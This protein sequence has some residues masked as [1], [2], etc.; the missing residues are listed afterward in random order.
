MELNNS[1][2]LWVLAHIQ[3]CT[4]HPKPTHAYSRIILLLLFFFVAMLELQSIFN[5]QLYHTKHLY[6]CIYSTF[7]ANSLS[8]FVCLCEFSLKI[9][10]FVAGIA[11]HIGSYFCA[12]MWKNEKFNLKSVYGYKCIVYMLLVFRFNCLWIF[13]SFFSIIGRWWWWWRVRVCACAYVPENVWRHCM[14]DFAVAKSTNTAKQNET[15][16]NWCVCVCV[17]VGK[18]DRFNC[19]FA[20]RHLFLLAAICTVFFSLLFHFNFSSFRRIDL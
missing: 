13:C 2:G 14:D 11:G 12:Y 6:S 16:W 18:R 5:S 10:T 7:S 17:R 3:M 4:V 15:I 20:S 8:Q 19:R 1:C 9:P